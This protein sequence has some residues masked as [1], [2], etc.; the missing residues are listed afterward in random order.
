MHAEAQTSL[1]VPN[2]LALLPMVRAYVR[3]LAALAA[4]PAEEQERLIEASVV[5]CTDVIEHA[6]DPGEEAPIT[7]SG[8]LDAGTVTLGIHERGV[9]F[10]PALA[11]ADTP[12]EREDPGHGLVRGPRWERLQHLV[13][14][15]HWLSH[16]SDGMEVRL[17]KARP[18]TD[19][20]E[21]LPAAELAPFQPR[22]PLARE[23]AYTIQRLLPAHAVGV[24]Q[25]IYRAYGY[26]YPN[27]DLYSPERIAQ[28]NAA[29]QLISAVALDEAGAVVGHAALERPEPT[30]IAEVGQGVVAPAHRGRKLLERMLEV[31]DQEGRTLGLLSLYGQPVTSHTR[32]QQV[33]EA[34]GSTVCAVSLAHSPGSYT[35]RGITTATVA[36]RESLLLWCRHLTP[37][38]TVIVHA[39]PHHQPIL[40]RIYGEL[41]VS[42]DGR[43]PGRA[44]G[45]GHTRVSFRRAW[46]YG[47]IR[48]D[49][50]GSA[51]AA[52]VRRALRDLCDAAGAAV[53]YLELPLDDPGTPALCEA[54]ERLGFF[55]SGVGVNFAVRGDALRL[56]YLNCS[57]DFGLVQVASDISHELLAYVAAERE[58]LAPA[59]ERS[60]C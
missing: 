33:E 52:E 55:F 12:A 34:R 20:S 38:G 10:D 42:I 18:R 6:F 27:A 45:A 60:P 7:L 37:P 56:Q 43:S 50:V 58:R 25:C 15:A 49:R 40:E 59:R 8:A 14:E 36:Q 13:D 29:G 35:F 51:S 31:L 2:D 9:P 46:G 53:V 19:V 44:G 47:L 28:L 32:S 39:P 41:G 54:A 21:H 22:V 23:Q 5:A 3:E 26:S 57:L 16:G 17:V 4:L 1:T 30:P 48:V 24:A 11:A